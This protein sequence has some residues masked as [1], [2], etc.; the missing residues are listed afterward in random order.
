MKTRHLI[1][2]ALLS[3]ALI[4][5]AGASAKRTNLGALASGDFGIVGDGFD[6]S[7][8]FQDTVHSSL[9][10]AAKAGGWVVP[11]RQVQGKLAGGAMRPDSYTFADLAPGSYTVAMFGTAKYLRGY[12]SSYRVSVAAVPEIETWSMLLIGLGLAAYQ[13]HRKQKAL[14]QQVLIDEASGSA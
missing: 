10:S 14:G 12:A 4:S 11:V 2:G 1:M 7:R 6:V 9:K 8:S 13:L 5:P 3:L